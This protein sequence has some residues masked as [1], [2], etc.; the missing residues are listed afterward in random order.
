[1]NSE[2]ITPNKNR[3][4]RLRA[5]LLLCPGPQPAQRNSTVPFPTVRLRV[6]VLGK[7]LGML[8]GLATFP[9][10]SQSRLP[11]DHLT[12]QRATV[13]TYRP[14]AKVF[15]VWI[16]PAVFRRIAFKIETGA[17]DTLH[18]YLADRL[19]YE[20][21]GPLGKS[22]YGA[23]F[24]FTLAADSLCQQPFTLIDRPHRTYT[25]FTIKPTCRR[26]WIYKLPEG[27]WY[28]RQSKYVVDFE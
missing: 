16:D 9:G 1:M 21:I 17:Q 6:G 4:V 3:N 20:Y 28:V 22:R 25:T 26:V 8:L 12:A 24:H 15:H 11:L 13:R 2:T 19:V 5:R 23:D 7:G 18:L 14:P 27:G 10:W